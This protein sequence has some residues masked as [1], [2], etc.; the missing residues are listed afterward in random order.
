MEPRSAHPRG[1][2]PRGRRWRGAAPIQ[3]AILSGDDESGISLMQMEAGLDTG[4]VFA[5]AALP[6]GAEETAGELHDR[7]ATLGGALLVEQLDAI[8]AGE[9]TAAPQSEAGVSYA[10]KIKTADARLDWSRSAIDLHRLIRAYNPVPGARFEF[11]GE[12][13]K[14]W[15]A[16]LSQGVGEPAGKVVSSDRNG[17]V[18]ACG[19]GSLRL[20][21]LQRPGKGR[22]TAAEFAA[23]LDLRDV[24]F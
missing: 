3:A 23:Q 11:H 2:G 6:I 14:C 7:L 18:V 5:H 4:P 1:S 13:I 16:D 22:V 24:R 8:L 21:E 10:A 12:A 19:E 15:Q 9:L 17:V 20:T